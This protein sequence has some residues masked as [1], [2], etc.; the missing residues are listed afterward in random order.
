MIPLPAANI[1]TGPLLRSAEQFKGVHRF[2]SLQGDF[3]QRA[4]REND[5]RLLPPFL[6]Q[7]GDRIEKE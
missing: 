7:D 4:S 3:L 6:P 5:D 2:V 1:Q